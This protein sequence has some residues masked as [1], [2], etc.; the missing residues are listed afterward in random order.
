VRI[1]DTVAGDGGQGD[2]GKGLGGCHGR[3]ADRDPI[4]ADFN[5]SWRIYLGRVK[6][7]EE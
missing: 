7:S 1:H 6:G 4:A 2:G 5:P 3:H